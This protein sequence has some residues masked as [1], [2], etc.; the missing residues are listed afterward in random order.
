MATTVNVYVDPNAAGAN[1]GTSWANAYTALQTAE[2]ANDVDITAATG[3]DT[4]VIF[5]CKSSAGGADATASIIGWTTSA[6]NYI[7]IQ[8]GY[9]AGETGTPGTPEYPGK[10]ST[11]YYHVE[12]TNGSAGGVSLNEDYF[13]IDKILSQA[14]VTETG[15]GFVVANINATNNDARFSDCIAKGVCSGT[16]VGYGYRI[17]DLD[18]IITMSNCIAHDF[19]IE[20]DSGFIGF[21]VSCATANLYNCLAYNNYIGFRENAGVVNIYNSV[22]FNNT[23]DFLGSP[24]VISHCSSDDNDTTDATNIDETAGGKTWADSFPDAATGD[25]TLK[26][27]S[28]LIGAGNPA[29]DADVSINGVTRGDPCDVGPWEYVAAGGLSIPVAMHHYKMMRNA[30]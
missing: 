12:E 27:G 4:I 5:H 24:D 30:A 3:N 28:P 22:A 13:R 2:A 8:G 14:T 15:Y 25:F 19:Y 16:G 9:A 20:D 18:V 26:V 7:L 10:Y 21:F 1:N 11:A 6:G 17:N 23:D 29:T